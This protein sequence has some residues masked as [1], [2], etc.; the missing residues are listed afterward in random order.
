VVK[1]T[2]D[3]STPTCNSTVWSNRTFDATTTLKVIACDAAGNASSVNTYTYTKDGT[4]P[5][6]TANGVPNNWTGNNITITFSVENK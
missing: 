2:T 3:G 4:L 5:V 6:T 1:Y